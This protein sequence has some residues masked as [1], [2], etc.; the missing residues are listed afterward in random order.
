MEN[1][2]TASVC[3]ESRRV[4]LAYTL[5][6]VF[7]FA[8]ILSSFTPLIEAVQFPRN[9][10][11]TEA[12]W[13]AELGELS[14]VR[15]ELLNSHLDE[16]VAK[17]EQNPELLA[18]ILALTAETNTHTAITK[19][20]E[21]QKNLN[22]AQ[23]TNMDDELVDQASRIFAKL[24]QAEVVEYVEDAEGERTLANPELTGI[25][26]LTTK[27]TQYSLSASADKP[28]Y[29]Q[30]ENNTAN[31]AVSVGYVPFLANDSQAIIAENK[32]LHKDTWSNTDL[33]LT[34]TPQGVKED[35]ILK[36]ENAPL[37]F[38]YGVALEGLVPRLA[39]DGGIEY[40]DADDEVQ[41]YI[42]A[43]VIFDANGQENLAEYKL[44]SIE[45][46]EIWLNSQS[47]DLQ[48]TNLAYDAETKNWTYDA[49][50]TSAVILEATGEEDFN[51]LLEVADQLEEQIAAEQAATETEDLVFEEV[52][53]EE[54]IE[55][56][57]SE[58]IEEEQTPAEEVVA[59]VTEEVV[60]EQE[61]TEEITEENSEETPAEEEVLEEVVSAEE[62][63]AEEVAPEIAEEQTPT[64]EIIEE[65]V[66]E[67]AP[68]L[69]TLPMNREGYFIGKDGY[70][71]KDGVAY[72]LRYSTYVYVREDWN[73]PS[74]DGRL[75][76]SAYG[77]LLSLMDNAH[78]TKTARKP[79][80]KT[81][82]FVLLVSIPEAIADEMT[83]PLDLD[84]S[85]F[86]NFTAKGN[87]LFVADS[88][89]GG[90]AGAYTQANHFGRITRGT[91]A[92]QTGGTRT[93]ANA[94]TSAIDASGNVHSV[95][96]IA[97][98]QDWTADTTSLRT[99]TV[100]AK[101]TFTT[102]TC[103]EV[104]AG[105]DY[106][107]AGGVLKATLDKNTDNEIV[108]Y[109]D[110]YSAS[111]LS[112][113]KTLL[114]TG[115]SNG[116]H[117]VELE[118]VSLA[119][120]ARTG[121]DYLFGLDYLEAYTT[122]NELRDRTKISASN[123]AGTISTLVDTTLTEAD[124]TFNGHA[125]TFL[126]G[127]YQGRT[128][129]VTD[130]VQSTGTLTFTP[131]MS[132]AVALGTNYKLSQEAIFVNDQILRGNL[133]AATYSAIDNISS[134]AG[135]FSAWIKPDFAANA[136]AD[137]HEIFTSN[138]AKLYYN[139]ADDA[140]HFAI[141]DGTDWNK[142]VASTTQTFTADE[143]IHLGA[144]WNNTT[145]V[146]LYVNN[147]ITS[148]SAVW[149]EQTVSGEMTFGNN[150][151]GVIS[152]VQIFDYAMR[153][154]EM[155]DIFY[156]AT[157]AIN[158]SVD[159]FTA[160]NLK[161]NKQLL[162]NANLANT[163]N[164]TVGALA[165]SVQLSDTVSGTKVE[166]VVSAAPAP[167]MTGSGTQADPYVLTTCQHVQD[168]QNN[169]SAYYELGSDIDCSETSSWNSGY[170]FDPIGDNTNQF[171]GHFDGKGY[172]ISDL[173]INRPSE[174]YVA[175]FGY[176]SSATVQNVGLEN[177]NVT[178][179][180][181]TSGLVGRNYSSSTITNSYVTGDITGN[182]YVGGLVG[183]NNN[184]SSIVDSNTNTN[185]FGSDHIG[186]LVGWNYS[187]TITNSYAIGN[188][189]G[190]YIV[191]GL[192]GQ[193]DSSTITNSYATGDVTSSSNDVGGFIGKNTNSSTV[194]DSYS[195]GN[196]SGVERVGGFVGQNNGS[197]S[198][199][200]N[201]YSSS[202]ATGSDSSLGGFAGY[203]DGS[204]TIKNVYAVGSVNQTGGGSSFT[205]RLVGKQYATLTNSYYWSGSTCT[206]C[207][208]TYGTAEATLANF[209]ASSHAVY[210]GSPAWDFTTPVWYAQS[211]DFPKFTAEIARTGSGTQA[212]PYVLYTCQH[213]QDIQNNLS[214]YYELG[215]DIDCSITST[216]NSGA[217][218]AP[219]RQASP[220]FTGHFDGKGFA[221]SNLYINRPSENYVALFGYTSGATIQNITLS[222]VD[223]IGQ[224]NVGGIAGYAYSSSQVTNAHVTGKITSTTS[225]GAFS[226]TGGVAGS[227]HTNSSISNSSANLIITNQGHSTAGLAG[228]AYQST[229]TNSY[230]QGEITGG[231]YY[232]GGLVGDNESSS[233]SNSYS[234][235]KVKG[236]NNVGGLAGYSHANSTITNSHATG[237]VNGTS[238]VG[239]LVGYNYSNSTITKS[240]ATGVVSGANQVGGLVGYSSSATVTDSYS[241]GAVSG[242]M[243]TGGLIGQS[244]GSIITNSYSTSSVTSN[245]WYAGGLV[246]LSNN[247]STIQN[248]YSVGSVEQTNSSY[249]SGTGPFIGFQSSSTLT[250][251]YYWSGSTCTN[252][253]AT[254]GTAEATL[255]NFYASSHAVYTGSPAWD[256]AST[257]TEY[258]DALPTI[259][260]ETAPTFASVARTVVST[261]AN[262][263]EIILGA[264][265]L[266]SAG[267][268]RVTIDAGTPQQ[269][270]T[271]IDTYSTENLTNK[272][273]LVATGLTAGVHTVRI[274]KTN[275]KNPASTGVDVYPK[276][277]EGL[278][279]S[280]TT[281][282]SLTVNG[283]IVDA[284][285]DQ[286][287]TYPAS[288]NISAAEGTLEF[289]TNSNAIASKT[290]IDTRDASNQNGLAISADGSS[291]LIF[292]Y[293]NASA[294][295]STSAAGS[296]NLV[297]SANHI[298]ARWYQTG[299]N[300]TLSLYLNG[301]KISETTSAFTPSTHTV[302][303]REATGVSI[304]DLAI[305]SH[306]FA[307]GGVAV[308]GSVSA[309]SE[310][311]RAY[312][313]LGHKAEAMHK[314][315]L[316]DT[317][318]INTSGTYFLD[319]S[320]IANANAYVN[321]QKV[322]ILTNKAGTFARL[323]GALTS[324]TNT[325]AIDTISTEA[326]IKSANGVALIGSAQ[327]AR[328]EKIYYESYSA[329][330][331]TGVTRGIDGTS[332]SAWAD[333]A[334]IEIL[335]SVALANN[336]A[337]GDDVYIDY[338]YLASANERSFDTV[339]MTSL[340]F[341]DGFTGGQTSTA[342]EKMSATFYGNAV[343]LV[344]TGNTTDGA[345]MQFI[346][347]EGTANER[348]II[349]D[350]NLANGKQVKLLSS[351]LGEG[352][353]TLRG[354]VLSGTARILGI[355]SNG[356]Q[357]ILKD[358][359]DLDVVT[360][361][362]L[363]NM[364]LDELLSGTVAVNAV[365]YYSP[366]DEGNDTWR[367]TTSASWYAEAG[368]YPRN[369]YIIASDS[370]L[371][372]FDESDNLPWA[373]F[374]VG[375]NNAIQ[376]AV[377]SIAAQN[378]VIYVATDTGTVK[379]DLVNDE[380]SKIMGTT[381]LDSGWLDFTDR[382]SLEFAYTGDTTATE[383]ATALSISGAI[384]AIGTKNIATPAN[385][386]VYLYDTANSTVDQTN[387][388]GAEVKAVYT[389]GTNI[390]YATA[391]KVAKYAEAVAET[392]N[393]TLGGNALVSDGTN[394][395]LGYASGIAKL[396]LSDVST[397]N[398]TFI[399]QSGGTHN[400]LAGT[401]NIVTAM[402]YDAANSRLIVGTNSGVEASGAVSVI[403]DLA[404]A[405]R[406][407]SEYKDEGAGLGSSQILAVDSATVNKNTTTAFMAGSGTQSS[408]YVITTCQ[409]LQ[410]MQNNLSAYYELG[411]DIDCSETSSWNSG[412]GFDPIGDGTT[413]FTG[414][415]DGKGY[416]ISDLYIN[417]PSTNFIG[418]F[419]YTSSATVQN[420]GL[421]NISVAGYN[422]VGGLVGNSLKSSVRNSY[423]TGNVSAANG[424]L[425]GL[426]GT[427]NDNNSG[428]SFVDKCYSTANVTGNMY[429]GGL[430]GNPTQGAVITNSYAT[431]DVS[432]AGDVGGFAGNNY[433]SPITNCYAT[434]NVTG[435]SSNV[436]GFVGLTYN[437]ITNSY[438]T[439][440]VSGDASNASSTGRFVGSFGIGGSQTNS[441]YWS[442]STCTNCGSTNGTAEATLSNFYS[443]SH[444]VYTGS[445]A[446]DFS[447]PVWYAQSSDFP[448]FTADTART[449]SGTQADPYVLYTCQHVQDMRNNLSAYYELGS[450][451][452]CSA[453]SSWNSGY[454]FIPVGGH[455][456][457]GA[458]SSSY[459][460]GHFDGKGFTISDLYINRTSNTGTDP[461]HGHYIGLFGYTSGATVQNVGLENVNVTGIYRIGGLVGYIY[462]STIK[463]S[464]TTGTV[465]SGTYQ[466]HAYLG[467]VIGDSDSSTMEKLHSSCSVVSLGSSIGGLLGKNYYSNVIDC[468][469]NG[470]VSGVNSVGG[471]VGSQGN[472]N[473]IRNSYSTGNVSASAEWVG[474][475][476]GILNGG[477]VVNSY[478]TGNV[479]NS[480]T[481]SYYTGRLVGGVYQGNGSI[482][483]SYYWS[484]STCTN[485]SV[486]NGTAEATL[487]NFY[488]SSHAVYTGSP[489]WDF[490][491]TWVASGSTFPA[492]EA[493][494][495][496]LA[497]GEYNVLV[498]TV[499]GFD[500]VEF[501]NTISPNTPEVTDDGASTTTD[502]SL[503][504]MWTVAESQVSEYQYCIS[505]DALDCTIGQVRGWTAVGTNTE[506]TPAGLVLATGS[507]YYFH[508]K[509]K[510]S[511]DLWSA[512]GHSDGIQ[513]T[514]PAI[515]PS[516]PTLVSPA[517]ADLISDNTPTLSAHYHDGNL[518]DTGTTEYRM[519]TTQAGCLDNSTVQHF[520]SS[521]ETATSDEDST[522][523]LATAASDGTYYWCARNND[524]SL[525]SAWTS[526]GSFTIDAT[527][528]SVAADALTTPSGGE[529]WVK[530]FAQ[531]I[532]WDTA[533]VTDAHFSATPIKLEY[534][535]DS[536]SN[537]T[538]IVEATENDG[539]YSWT[540]PDILSTQ[541][542]VRITAT[543]TL[544]QSS[545][546]T[547]DADFSLVNPTPTTTE[548]I[549][550]NNQIGG[551][552]ESMSELKVRV[553]NGTGYY[554][555][556]ND[557]EVIY[558]ITSTPIAP[559][560]TGQALSFTAS[561][562]G[563]SNTIQTSGNSIS[564]WTDAS[565]Y[566]SA[567]FQL[568]DRAGVYEITA[569]F[570]DGTGAKTQTFTVIE[571]EVL[572][573]D[574]S[575]ASIAM[576]NNPNTASADAGTV[577]LTFETNAGSYDIVATPDQWLTHSV[578]GSHQIANWDGAH[579][580]A[581]D[582]NADTT[583]PTSFA[584]S[585]Q[586]PAATTVYSCSGDAC[587]G[588]QTITIDF[589]TDIDFDVRSG[590]YNASI[591]FSIANVAF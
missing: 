506:I 428:T 301:K 251:S 336:P 149:T 549:S 358:T 36:N 202:S 498:G 334:I 337:E 61:I 583:I 485:C 124:D 372:I 143:V 137:L 238:Y 100:G 155:G 370:A 480:N 85:T 375:A 68:E 5:I 56:Q 237:S 489:A 46:A 87:R 273:F 284:V 453:T 548:V 366:A 471:L 586:N 516:A 564:V 329:G 225:G 369:S 223:I 578:E 563:G 209:Y 540:T 89:S 377:N 285:L 255:A 203:N 176:T 196:V 538:V 393:T 113:Q 271:E 62:I 45:D 420:V 250:N 247:S 40:I 99:N 553:G 185:I 44:L 267:I 514:K 159:Q 327:S 536:G 232:I 239:G 401:T 581:W 373:T 127:T 349:A 339:Q 474:G 269:I 567:N 328:R 249:S 392:A 484:G 450:D 341:T 500:V 75:P 178:G 187:S 190:D 462:S 153:A 326:N 175:L 431:G 31:G 15:P 156:A 88:L 523:T 559:V 58:E 164:D 111:A 323:N 425:G 48:I 41:M 17:A 354:V 13:T 486:V 160:Q 96:N 206:N 532:T 533:K 95:S 518:G 427:L 39:S 200:E 283:R 569:T 192:V 469:A 3:R 395:F 183:W 116:T 135:A 291:N 227:L 421:E 195:T 234:T 330:T 53:S 446:W 481:G 324:T 543:D 317:L 236:T 579:G 408:P 524:G 547:S 325:F 276:F 555:G 181:S 585:G 413:Q 315:Y 385:S 6:F 128:V 221:I 433:N 105:L 414:H 456:S 23:N 380:I 22:V 403:A 492:F 293:T 390:Y 147:I 546:D 120:A 584:I 477:S 582:N 252:C 191:G 29:F 573:F 37:E 444:A 161:N 282:N 359:G 305:Y 410:D 210:T 51:Q 193:N 422:N 230:S 482:S 449:G 263:T 264:D 279:T 248:S 296:A 228:Q 566:A 347:D 91:E 114:A 222:N 18:E 74:E 379:L 214:A 415:F 146:K 470:D 287:V 20:V 174:S 378:G 348:R 292:T 468:Y 346:L 306:A 224:K 406:I 416:V 245:N 504:V 152:E 302:I 303:S 118:L 145:G 148:T 172:V 562:T 520:G 132:G 215:R 98:S 115:L 537:W 432:G 313:T 30:I 577:T 73:T 150:F 447:T 268:A 229:I 217:G 512:V 270:I 539:T 545:S 507:T 27:S 90:Q 169:L 308:A 452:D 355:I 240:Y 588:P 97:S 162:F 242:A 34:T 342:G 460:T 272:R 424:S 350:T 356:H 550:G 345:Q 534:S 517:E 158:Q 129:Y 86:I 519:A 35:L 139:G 19:L 442:G 338:D 423:S 84:P 42:P 24:T 220:Y 589:H 387:S 386:N 496:P 511:N 14:K 107:T 117:T 55:E 531:D 204:A 331:F 290:L 371:F 157:P 28:G 382:N 409:Q 376:S 458:S 448:K 487:S 219:I 320:G 110:T 501:A 580:M 316:T 140:F 154:V 170:G 93:L 50:D 475:L 503:H 419:G 576:N 321:G 535:T 527:A 439:G 246:G 80:P 461:N 542:R 94:L 544:A 437:S 126:S 38:A 465:S 381:V 106:G 521:A 11:A 231:D 436:G 136:D 144:T 70:Y 412:Y 463:N 1:T 352:I 260:V 344:F 177:V 199:I 388:A 391:S 254:Y 430:I 194:T 340:G 26:Q 509:A 357:P 300:M 182:D 65:V 404:S 261:P 476:L 141:F 82:Q 505:T 277:I 466:Y 394:I 121:S 513:V 78:K 557:V 64:E 411:N 397:V 262:T 186:G 591:P 258:T 259:T 167:A 556:E 133:N 52:V 57:V 515:A 551:V 389:D 571:R 445:P 286:A 125:L 25:N 365:D 8:N 218:F 257:W 243:Q 467:G 184:Y 575:A 455:T 396:S 541:V 299:A 122:G 226:Y 76:D 33:L 479:E 205:G 400:I 101:V 367:E 79:F 274:E 47:E 131:A 374:V 168:M 103:T 233:I 361:D 102:T 399:A 454:G 10:K 526:M 502:N 572:T 560:A 558:T 71:Y 405:P 438:A 288:G 253:G 570:D 60:S 207:G 179:S 244:Y 12:L 319:E 440:N 83:Y 318:V 472:G 441:Y 590:T 398:A 280:S 552:G 151:A 59:E 312:A 180:D 241:T 407:L 213:V 189:T 197:S 119:N 426:I 265:T 332:A 561:N 459:F 435:T 198:T 351:D 304:Y 508:V 275:T 109:I 54:V 473:T 587:Q 309:D 294:S 478:S 434:G 443:S 530:D 278:T 364:L 4:T 494:Q 69:P 216:W 464:Y 212:D 417:R 112:E 32:V 483:N 188:T 525:Q 510:N 574:F 108:N 297:A 104:W 138:V 266:P 295:I 565:G 72:E 528:P 314:I 335:G 322:D 166:I 289:W 491:D 402:K 333:N 362:L 49:L 490:T 173:Y 92:A 522:W 171:T 281:A 66:V 418:L 201:C 142:S 554:V 256:F 368:E 67:V 363:Q 163:P 208:A 77:E 21:I 235:V 499:T 211:A 360:A 457:T 123:S 134:A 451:I 568:G 529:S 384:L 7:V 495:T 81:T 9:A 493:V 16:L 2:K 130:Y 307:D 383:Q 311:G 343:S 63:P 488:S 497:S 165:G 353:H 429:I 310:V 43:P 298:L